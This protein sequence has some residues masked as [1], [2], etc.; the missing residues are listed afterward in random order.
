M[1][2]MLML[3][4]LLMF[5]LS[6]FAMSSKPMTDEEILD[7]NQKCAMTYMRGLENLKR[8]YNAFNDR[9]LNKYEF[10]ASLAANDI[11]VKAGAGICRG[12]YEAP[13]YKSCLDFLEKQYND[14]REYSKIKSVLTG[15]QNSVRRG[16]FDLAGDF[17]TAGGAS[18]ACETSGIQLYEYR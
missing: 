12:L 13:R 9:R 18:L 5:S 11:A 10:A 17:F 4:S 6:S 16:L 8:D 1:K 15:V 2:K 14:I 7:I 3:L